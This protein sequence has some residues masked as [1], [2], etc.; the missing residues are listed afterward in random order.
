MGTD[1]SC[2][3]AMFSPRSVGGEQHMVLCS[4]HTPE[5]V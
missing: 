1:R 3:T 5:A 2:M 4:R